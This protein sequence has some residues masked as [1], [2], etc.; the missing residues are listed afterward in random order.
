MKSKKK[1]LQPS[2]KERG[3]GS[4]QSKRIN[5]P[6]SEFE[7]HGLN[8]FQVEEESLKTTNSEAKSSDKKNTFYKNKTKGFLNS[9][10]MCINELE[11]RNSANLVKKVKL[12]LI[13]I[14]KG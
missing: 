5:S 14:G 4:I 7:I 11:V 12:K 2:S 8:S 10:N 1:I 9:L 3:K 13:Y 6:N